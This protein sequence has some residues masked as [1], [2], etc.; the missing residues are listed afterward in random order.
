MWPWQAL[1]RRK[2][3]AIYNTGPHSRGC[4]TTTLQNCSEVWWSWSGVKMQWLMENVLFKKQKGK[5]RPFGG[6][7]RRQHLLN[8]TAND[9]WEFSS[10]KV[11]SCVPL[12]DTS[13]LP[14]E[15]EMSLIC[16][17]SQP[18]QVTSQT[19]HCPQP[20]LKISLLPFLRWKER[21]ESENT[22]FFLSYTHTHTLGLF[23]GLNPTSPQHLCFLVVSPEVSLWVK[24]YLDLGCPSSVKKNFKQV[25]LITTVALPC[26]QANYQKEA[27]ITLHQSSQPRWL[28]S[29][30]G[31]FTVC[32]AVFNC[33]NW[34]K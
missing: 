24:K 3:R 20:L 12:F 33:H 2:K 19:K 34:E 25:G 31:Y 14:S 13:L 32:G 29:S 9:E 6:K 16:T 23:S 15:N 5:L 27:P 26:P 11:R 30:G 17:K 21:G 28:W 8:R 7:Q 22:S 10:Q 4:K 1:K 18:F